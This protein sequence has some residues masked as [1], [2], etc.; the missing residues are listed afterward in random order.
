MSALKSPH[1]GKPTLSLAVDIVAAIKNKLTSPE[2]V[3]DECL[4]RID[5]HEPSVQAWAWQDAG[6]ARRA[7]QALKPQMPDQ[8]LYGLPIG[9]KDIIDTVDMPT[10]YGS[11]LYANHHAD[12]DAK[13]V[14]RLRAA[15]AIILGKTVTTEFAY[16]QPGPTS[17][18]HDLLHTPGGS[19]SGS[20]AA[21]AAGMVPVALGSQTGGSTIRPSAYCGIVGFKP[22]FSAVTMQGIRPLA[23][24]MDTIGI[25]ALSVADVALLYPVLVGIQVDEKQDESYSRIEPLRVG[26]YPGPHAAEADVD[27]RDALERAASL[28]AANGIVMHCVDLPAPLFVGLSEANRTIMAYEASRVA[29]QDYARGRDFL[30]PVTRTFLEAGQRIHVAEYCKALEL[31]RRCQSL[32]SN[33]MQE[34]DVLM[35]FSAPSEAPLKSQGTGNSIFNRAWSTIGAP[36]LTLPFGYGKSGVLPLGIQLVGVH[37]DDCKLLKNGVVIEKIWLEAG[38]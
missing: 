29:A 23:P 17:N 31:A 12:A 4:R 6:Q 15:G 10:C 36:C 26:Y 38:R 37:G 7:V 8:R 2:E 11:A 30:G 33:A 32:F 3:L 20:A 19:S 28:V 13:V 25:H 35:T 21:V 9:I 24:S 1:R 18:P 22:T 27:T 5:E 14:S 16:A 34:C